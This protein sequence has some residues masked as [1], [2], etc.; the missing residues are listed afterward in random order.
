MFL[1]FFADLRKQFLSAPVSTSVK[2][3]EPTSLRCFGPPG[4]PAAQIS[5]LKNGSPFQPEPNS[6]IIISSEGLLISE[7]TLQ[8][9]I[10]D[11]LNLSTVQTLFYT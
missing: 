8:V 2:L 7:A 11:I 9:C 3:F 6:N 10:L 4:V 1:I 5:W